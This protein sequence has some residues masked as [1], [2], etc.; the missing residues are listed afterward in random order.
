MSLR[1]PIRIATRESALAMWQTRHVAERL[2][3]AHPGLQIELKP[4]TTKGDQMLDQ[5]LASIGG[6]GLFLKEL[7]KAMLDGEADIAVH[8]MKDVPYQMPHEF[9]I[10]AILERANPLDALVGCAGLDKLA[11]GA[12]V[13]TSS[14]RRRAQLLSMRPDLNIKDLRGNVNTRLAKLDSGQYDA[15]VLAAAGLTRLGMEQRIGG[16]LSPPEWLPAA[17]QGAV[18]IECRIDDDKI[19]PLLDALHHEPTAARVCA[20]RA[21][22]AQLGADCHMP[23]A[24]FAT[25]DGDQLHLKARVLA[26]D[27]K[28]LLDAGASGLVQNWSDLGADV[29]CKLLKLGAA[30]CLATTA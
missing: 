15:I 23:L 25:L 6:K 3:K 27:G 19:S 17:A 2:Q 4:M 24:A 18:G 22:A 7:E 20:E 1:R 8:S 14:L 11:K 5:S 16:L 30:D 21:V 9:R 26:V 13:G 10:G 28:Q 29:G 12:V